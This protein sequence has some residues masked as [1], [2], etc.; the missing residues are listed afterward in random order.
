MRGDSIVDATVR[1]PSFDTPIVLVADASLECEVVPGAPADGAGEVTAVFDL[2]QVA[3]RPDAQAVWDAVVDKTR[4]PE[5]TRPIRV[6]TIRQ[7]FESTRRQRAGSHRRAGRGLRAGRQRGAQCRRA[8]GRYQGPAA[9]R[10][11]MIRSSAPARPVRVTVIRVGGQA[12]DADWR[13]DT[14]GI[15]FPTVAPAPPPQ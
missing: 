15:L 14:T 12:R 9:A 4:L 2:D 7:T 13:V 11:I 3:A 1:G 8:R 5:A 6:K 10:R